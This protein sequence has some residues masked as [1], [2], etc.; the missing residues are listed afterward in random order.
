MQPKNAIYECCA[1]E[2][3][4]DKAISYNKSLH[5]PSYIN[6]ILLTTDKTST[7]SLRYKIKKLLRTYQ[8]NI[9]KSSQ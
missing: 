1:I 5:L 3:K 8:C 9:C 7:V 6:A 4:S 2:R